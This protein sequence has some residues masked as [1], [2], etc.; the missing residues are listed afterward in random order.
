MNLTVYIWTWAILAVVVLCLALYRFTL[1][2]HED[3]SLHVSA[4][5]AQQVAQQQVVF[6]KLNRVEFWGKLLTIV[7]VLY[8]LVIAG[9]YLYHS[10]LQSSQVTG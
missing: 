1:A 5:E 7:V 8:G 6:G 2:G 4:V 9:L 10:W 3:E